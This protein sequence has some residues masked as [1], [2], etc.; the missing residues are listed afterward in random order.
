MRKV[1]AAEMRE[2]DRC[3][4]QEFGIPG[5]VL[6]ENAGRGAA[7]V[8]LDMLKGADN[9]K[10]AVVCGQGNNGGDGYVIARHLHNAGISVVVRIVAPREKIA[11]DALINLSII[12]KMKLD[13]QFISADSLDFSDATI[14]VDALL[15][16][17]LSGAVREPYLTAIR[18]INAAAKPVLAVD[19]P[20]GLNSDTGEVLGEC[21][22]AARTVT[23]AL[24]K[25]GFTIKA[26]PAVAGPV[27]VV[28]IGVPRELFL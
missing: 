7:T 27:T 12:E 14:I 9:P 4:I 13:V 25:I 20:S 16:T 8:A 5:V 3:A 11:G 24:P 2:I 6:M 1:T 10:A 17:G 15:G 21:V 22:R 26:G 28:D 18:K 19:I 23:F